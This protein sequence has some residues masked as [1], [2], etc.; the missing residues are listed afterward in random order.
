MGVPSRAESFPYIVLEAQAAGLPLIASNVGGIPEM[1]EPASLVP[2]DD[3]SALAERIATALNDP[4]AR[5]LAVR[6]ISALKARFS[7]AIMAESALE[8]YAGLTGGRA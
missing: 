6:R 7:I 1:T 2:P 4:E 3:P 5:E 8:F